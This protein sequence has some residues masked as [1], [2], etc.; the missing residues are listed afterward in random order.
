ML[1]VTLR[2]SSAETVPK[3][4]QV[5]HETKRIRHKNG[6]EEEL[7]QYVR[8]D[9]EQPTSI[10]KK[11]P[12]VIKL[13]DDSGSGYKPPESLTIYLS[14]IPMPELEPKKPATTSS[15][16]RE[17]PISKKALE[18][19]LKRIEK[20]EEKQ[21]REREKLQKKTKGKDKAN[22]SGRARS[23]DRD[24]SAAPVPSQRVH[25]HQPSPSSSQLRP[26]S[27]SRPVRPVSAHG[28]I[29]GYPHP[30]YPPPPPQ[31]VNAPSGLFDKL[32]RW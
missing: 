7:H 27:S 13:D 18:K 26:P 28:A 5:L 17:S 3:V 23:L 20:E 12:R 32:R 30:P 2:S 11:G 14:K 21:R 29:P 8:Y 1:F 22:D 31:P 15:P 19:E 6:L 24:S 4:L 10:G 16:V 25:P 9:S